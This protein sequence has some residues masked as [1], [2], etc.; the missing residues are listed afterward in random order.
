MFGGITRTS[1]LQCETGR[2]KKIET[3]DA[4]RCTQIESDKVRQSASHRYYLRSSAVSKPSC[5]HL[6]NHPIHAA[7]DAPKR[8]GA[9]Q[10][11][12]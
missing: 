10:M 7:W 1:S 11:S 9:S 4:R 12:A 5:C 2:Q 8:G 3:A 6:L